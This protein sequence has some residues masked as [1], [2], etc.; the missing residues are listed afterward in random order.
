MASAM[1]L[2]EETPHFAYHR[3]CADHARRGLICTERSNSLDLIEKAKRKNLEIITPEELAK[4]DAQ[5]GHDR[6]AT[7]GEASPHYVPA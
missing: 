5:I 7:I 2:G 4:R 3:D 1:T 6:R